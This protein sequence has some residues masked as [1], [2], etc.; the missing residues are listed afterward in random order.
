MRSEDEESVIERRLRKAA[1]EIRNFEMYDYVLVND[2][3]DRSTET[4]VSIVRAERVRRARV[5]DQVRT[6]LDTFERR[7]GDD[8]H[9]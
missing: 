4:L 6:I 9:V 1:D 7:R 2:D 3:L 5:A 8:P